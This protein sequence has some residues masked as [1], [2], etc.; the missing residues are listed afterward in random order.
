VTATGG[1]A[2]DRRAPED[3]STA[4][5]RWRWRG[6]CRFDY[7]NVLQGAGYL[8]AKLD[9]PR[10]D[11]WSRPMR[12]GMNIWLKAQQNITYTPK[13]RPSRQ[14]AWWWWWWCVC[15]CVCVCGVQR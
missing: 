10:K 8:L 7:N 4:V 12:E 5:C 13:V 14:G 9:P 3:A 15:V 6:E 11:V 2:R 1:R